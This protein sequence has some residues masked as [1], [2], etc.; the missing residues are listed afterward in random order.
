METKRKVEVIENDKFENYDSTFISIRRCEELFDNLTDDVTIG[1]NSLR[2]P[3]KHI[4]LN[5]RTKPEVN[6]AGM[7]VEP[8]SD[9]LNP[10]IKNP[11]IRNVSACNLLCTEV[12]STKD[13]VDSL[14]NDIIDTAMKM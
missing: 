5:E 10:K 9:M 8:K 14:L 6:Y 13:F 7:T 3:E 4:E 12:E 11:L 1:P 2:M